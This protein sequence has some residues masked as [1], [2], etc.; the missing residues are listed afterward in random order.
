MLLVS[1]K[2]S[3]T[4]TT[5]PTTTTP[6]TTTTTTTAIP[7][8]GW[9]MGATSYTSVYVSR[10]G[11]TGSSSGAAVGLTAL[12]AAPTAST[13]NKCTIYLPSYP[14]AGGTFRVV[15]VGS[16][17]TLGATEVGVTAQLASSSAYYAS[18]GLDGIDVTVT[19]TGGKIKVVV[20]DV[21]VKNI[22][23]SDSMKLT[24][25]ILEN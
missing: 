17:V 20:P 15:K 11:P 22:A 9:K 2:K 1:C 3:T 23:G 4:T 25:T 10:S 21:W 7:T 13:I 8:N 12:D 5:T 19:V 14:T 6:T 24:G 16:V 18:T